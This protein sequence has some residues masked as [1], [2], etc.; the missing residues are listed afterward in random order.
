M[1]VIYFRLTKASEK[2]QEEYRISID[3]NVNNSD[4]LANNYVNIFELQS[5]LL[6][7]T[8][9]MKTYIQN[10]NKIIQAFFMCL[11]QYKWL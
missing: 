9:E 10:K 8:T 4:H 3:C 11:D 1:L 6:Q 7:T 5:H 2:K